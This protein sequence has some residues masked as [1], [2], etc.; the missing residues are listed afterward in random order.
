MV[1][2]GGP[3]GSLSFGRGLCPLGGKLEL[4]RPWGSQAVSP[5]VSLRLSPY[6]G[7]GGPRVCPSHGGVPPGL[8]PA[9]EGSA[10]PPQSCPCIWGSQQWGGAQVG[11][12]GISGV[13]RTALPTEVPLLLAPQLSPPIWEMGDPWSVPGVGVLV[14]GGGGVLTSVLLMGSW[15]WGGVRVCPCSGVLGGPSGISLRWG[16]GGVPRSV[17]A[18]GY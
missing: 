5:H 6:G 13:L 4:L 10:P 15:E 8:S 18:M 3:R 2:L 9:L 7:S 16:S 12:M 11:P 14:G 1:S 17:P